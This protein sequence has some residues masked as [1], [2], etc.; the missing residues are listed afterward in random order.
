MWTEELSM[1]ATCTIRIFS[2]D[3]MKFILKKL[4]I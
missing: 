2:D 4:H 3:D 1:H